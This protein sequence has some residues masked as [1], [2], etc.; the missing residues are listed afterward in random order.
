M[1]AV[2]ITSVC[3]GLRYAVGTSRARDGR[4][5]A[6]SVVRVADCREGDRVTEP[7]TT[8]QPGHREGRVTRVKIVR[9]RVGDFLVTATPYFLGAWAQRAQAAR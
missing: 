8:A 6:R 9:L 7:G 2:V 4:R 3:L 5:R 1:S